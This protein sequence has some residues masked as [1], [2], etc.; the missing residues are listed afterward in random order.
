MIRSVGMRARKIAIWAFSSLS[1]ALCRGMKKWLRNTKRRDKVEF[2]LPGPTTAFNKMPLCQRDGA[3]L[4]FGTPLREG[5]NGAEQ[6][7]G[8]HKA[9]EGGRDPALPLI[10]SIK[11]LQAASLPPP[12]QP[13]KRR[14]EFRSCP[15]WLPLA[16]ER[17]GCQVGS[18]R[19]FIKIEKSI[20][21]LGGRFYP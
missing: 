9:G 14:A 18:L 4:H 5:Q 17:V 12:D 1:C 7:G 11:M 6:E 15:K 21:C 8:R 3:H 2:I 16:R 13:H 10:P 19:H 20:I